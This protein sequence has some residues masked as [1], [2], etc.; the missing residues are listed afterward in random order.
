[1]FTYLECGITNRKSIHKQRKYASFLSSVFAF[2]CRRCFF[3]VSPVFFSKEIKGVNMCLRF[4]MNVWNE[5]TI[6]I[7]L[8]L[9]T[10]RAK[11][12]RP[13]YSESESE[14][15]IGDQVF[16][17]ANHQLFMGEMNFNFDI[18]SHFSNWYFDNRK[19]VHGSRSWW[20]TRCHGGGE[21]RFCLL[22]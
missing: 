12:I 22:Y 20:D 8:F 11:C 2:R 17:V 21:M 7:V 1:M 6:L 18:Y 9:S 4:E 5:T 3:F 15:E 10:Y 16:T 19:C 13:S 14:R